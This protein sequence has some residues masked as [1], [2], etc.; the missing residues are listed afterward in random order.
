MFSHRL[1]SHGCHEK[2]FRVTGVWGEGWRLGDCPEGCP[3]WTG[4]IT[5]QV[6]PTTSYTSERRFRVTGILGGERFRVTVVFGGGRW[7]LGCAGEH[8]VIL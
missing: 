7:R 5:T 4:D 1:I 8:I 2:R 6:D 3:G